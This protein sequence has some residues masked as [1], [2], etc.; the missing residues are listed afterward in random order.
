MA[1]FDEDDSWDYIMDI[2]KR[3]LENISQSFFD[4]YIQNNAKFRNDSGIASKIVRKLNGETCPWCR[5][6]AGSYVYGTEPHEVYQRHD[7]CDCTVTYMNGKS[8]TN[9]HTKEAEINDIKIVSDKRNMID[10]YIEDVTEKYNQIAN[11]GI[12]KI[13]IDEKAELSDKETT[14]FLF[15]RYG[16]NIHCL[17]ED[18]TEGKRPDAL[19]NGIYWEYKAPKSKNAIEDRIRYALT[20]IAEALNRESNPTAKRGIVLNISNFN[21]S[22]EVALKKIMTEMRCRCN[23]TTDIIVRKNDDVIKVLRIIK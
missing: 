10:D 8:S 11:P 23:Y 21:S 13:I 3:A 4:A 2:F 15:N 1:I 16:G 19:W 9:V 6:L 20:Q 18:S 5:A 22:D 7:N 14:K 17:Q 12:G